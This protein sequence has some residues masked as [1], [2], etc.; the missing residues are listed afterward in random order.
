MNSIQ[1]RLLPI[2]L[3]FW[4]I[5]AIPNQTKAQGIEFGITGGMNIS[6]HTN[7]F[8]FIDD[9]IDLTYTPK[10]VT[11]FQGGFILRKQLSESVRLQTEPSFILLGAR[12]NESFDL[13]GFEFQTDSRTRFLYLQMPLLL[14]FSTVPE[15]RTVYGREYPKTTYHITG[16][17]YG[18]YLPYASFEGTNIGDPVGISFEGEFQN[19]VT[20]QY[21]SYDGGLVFGLGFE[22]GLRSKIGFEARAMYSVFDASEYQGNTSPFSFKMHNMAATLSVYFIL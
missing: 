15:E 22:H 16:G 20:D 12:Y 4:F 3:L 1:L 2:C 11:G 21:K 7:K 18:G 10:V 13:R 8:K 5:S 6:T 14:Q 19:N 17:I 9:D